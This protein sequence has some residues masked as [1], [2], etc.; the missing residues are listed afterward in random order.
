MSVRVSAATRRYG[1]YPGKAR[2]P[3]ELRSDLDE[4]FSLISGQT[5]VKPS[6]FYGEFGGRKVDRDEISV[7][8]FPT[9]RLAASQ[10]A[11]ASISIPPASRIPSVR[12]F[13]LSHR[14]K[15]I[16][17]SGSSTVA[18]SRESALP[19]QGARQN[20][21]TNVWIP[22]GMKDTP[23]DRRGPR[24]RLA[25]SLDAVVQKKLPSKFTSIPSS[26]S[27]SARQ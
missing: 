6:R 25:V 15:G 17:Q 7:E 23:A 16:R 1:N 24:E 18:A 11:L 9:G 13:Y 8:R 27:C 19:S 12:R 10:S 2:T 20:L 22:D 26:P 14:D 21:I 3:E 5:P 4:T